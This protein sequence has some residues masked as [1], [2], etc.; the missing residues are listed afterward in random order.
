MLS[1]CP[2]ALRDT[3]GG[4]ARLMTFD[5]DLEKVHALALRSAQGPLRGREILMAQQGLQDA[6]ERALDASGG[7]Q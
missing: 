1:P 3:M 7:P 6:R 2:P 5:T 4:Y